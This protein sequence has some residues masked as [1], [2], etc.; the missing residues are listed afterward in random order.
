MH[1][2]V[3]IP[4]NGRKM[5]FRDKQLTN[6]APLMFLDTYEKVTTAL[7]DVVNKQTK[8]SVSL[9]LLKIS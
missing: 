7:L 6:R 3:K 4:K 1:F 9:W 8:Y 2:Q 5:I